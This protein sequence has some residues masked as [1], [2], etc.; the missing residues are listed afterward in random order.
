MNKIILILLLLFLV[1]CSNNEGETL[2]FQGEG[3][4]WKVKYVAV[5]SDNSQNA[6][7]TIVYIGEEEAPE[8]FDYKV[9]AMLSGNESSMGGAKLN[10]KGFIERTQLIT[11]SRVQND[12]II[13]T[14]LN[15]DDKT[16][17]VELM[18]K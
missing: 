17:K 7:F 4:N 1:A 8:S 11:G 9:S 10:E 3:D 15:W 18:L 2:N 6:T 16:E 12:E 13:I 14:E 5:N